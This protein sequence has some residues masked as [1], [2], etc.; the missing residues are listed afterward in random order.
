MLQTVVFGRL[1]A[2]AGLLLLLLSLLAETLFPLGAPGVVPVYAAPSLAMEVPPRGSTFFRQRLPSHT[3]TTPI[4]SSVVVKVPAVG[5]S[6]SA[7]SN[8][9]VV[10]NNTS[11]GVTPMLFKHKYPLTPGIVVSPAEA[12][13]K[14]NDGLF[15][16]TEA[17][18]NNIGKPLQLEDARKLSCKS[19]QSVT[20]LSKGANSNNSNQTELTGTATYYVT[21]LFCGSPQSWSTALTTNHSSILSAI[22]HTVEE[23]TSSARIG[24]AASVDFLFVLRQDSS[25]KII[26]DGSGGLLVDLTVNCSGTDFMR[27]RLLTGDEFASSL[28]L[29]NTTNITTAL[30]KASGT[31]AVAV[32][33]ATLARTTGD[34]L[35]CDGACKGAIAMGCVSAVLIA[36]CTAVTLISTC[37]LWHF[38]R[39]DGENATLQSVLV[40]LMGCKTPDTRA[41]ATSD[42]TARSIEV[43][44]HNS[45]W[46]SPSTVP[47][48]LD[49]RSEQ[50]N[51]QAT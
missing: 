23:Q 22:I 9:R 41:S 39:K 4:G 32:L 36:I 40:K 43:S 6:S 15:L 29:L 1:Y 34:L 28:L 18:L 51:V 49:S 35:F 27:G 19:V 16:R 20:L 24:C 17:A 33:C 47:Y 50:F 31:A 30:Q 10:I 8:A 3:K 21:L 2:R 5:L 48:G 42:T 11:M 37:Y 13:G 45:Q 26:G 46:N 25:F 38:V 44:S 12:A 14:T 7:G